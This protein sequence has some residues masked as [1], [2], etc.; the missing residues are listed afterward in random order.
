MSPLNKRLSK[1][2]LLVPIIMVVVFT[3]V[4]GGAYV[5]QSLKQEEAERKNRQ[6]KAQVNNLLQK[7]RF[8]RKQEALYNEY[9]EKYL[10]VTGNGLVQDFDRVKW[11]DGLLHLKKD[12]IISPFNMQYE[13]E[14]KLEQVHFKNY[15]MVK[16][17]FYFTRVNLNLGF[18]SD[19]D[20]IRFNDRMSTSISSLYM[21]EKCRVE[22]APEYLTNVSF[23]PDKGSLEAN[24]SYI[25]FQA[26]PKAIQSVEGDEQ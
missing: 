10:E 8:L 12:L 18:Q 2:F 15:K 3:L 4:L 24:C 25:V 23:V 6:L 21:P 5:D 17:I 13:P 22:I 20:L 14:Q 16:D 1:Q 9:G 19:L 7:V 26:K 11:V